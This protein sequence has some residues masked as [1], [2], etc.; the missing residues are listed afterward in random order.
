MRYLFWTT[1]SIGVLLASES[2]AEPK[3]TTGGE[4]R[5][6]GE[7]FNTP[8]PVTGMDESYELFNARAR[9]TADAAWEKISV[10]AVLQA[11]ASLGL[12]KNGAFAI[13]PVYTA[14]N[15]GV[16]DPGRISV[17][18]FSTAFKS[19]RF[20]AT[21]GRQ[22]YA[23]GVETMTGVPYLDA[24]KK[25]RLA[26]R[27][28]GNWD[29]V[30]VGRRFDGIALG[31]QSE[32]TAFD[33]FL[34]RPLSG[35]VNYKDAHE[36][37]DD[38]SVFGATITGR[39]DRWIPS[40]EARLFAIQYVDQ[41]PSAISASGED[42]RITTVGSSFLTGTQDT[43]LLL[44]GSYQFGDWGLVDQKAW[45]FFVEAGHKFE[46]TSGLATLRGGYAH[47]SGDDGGADHQSFFNLLP[48]NHKFMG[49]MDYNAFSNLREVFVQA[50]W[51]FDPR[52]KVRTAVHAFFLAKK[53]DAWYGG[54][55]PFNE[56]VL[57]YAARRPGSGDFLND[58]LG[59]EFDLDATI[60]L[61]KKHTIHLGGGVFWG[62][63][64]AGE[65]L[66]SKDDGLWGYLQ[67]V[68]RI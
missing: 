14:A 60:T 33:G 67:L 19:P 56:G 32:N 6:R 5:L 59:Q 15:T 48:T 8:A 45:A 64:A 27:L 28:I 23:G 57:G 24:I 12:P 63:K 41:R 43:D 22:K 44:W 3:I 16:T 36:W 35:G 49:S 50:T 4:L 61:P 52:V 51:V 54:S 38:L 55:G 31:T 9:G 26:E 40:A 2:F 29:W 42:L 46:T 11:A 62:D 21:L 53:T 10:H 30:N 13:G 1:L 66:K 17:L 39:Y 47:A 25:R 37:L 7:G 58:R 68:L 18:E 20:R 34:L 65:I